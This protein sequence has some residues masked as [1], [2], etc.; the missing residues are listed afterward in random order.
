MLSVNVPSQLVLASK[1]FTVSII[2]AVE[3][4]TV[5]WSGM[6]IPSVYLVTGSLESF[7]IRES[8][9]ELDTET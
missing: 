4:S 3:F 8:A 2:L 9:F 5:L 7:Q 1:S 6:A